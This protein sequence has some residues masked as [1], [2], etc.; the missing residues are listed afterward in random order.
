MFQTARNTIRVLVVGSLVLLVS[1]MVAPDAQGSLSW[2]SVYRKNRGNIVFQSRPFRTFSSNKGFAKIVRRA[3]RNRVLRRN[4][5]GT[6]SFYFVAFMKKPPKSHQVNLVWYRLGRKK[7]KEQVDYTRISVPPREVN[8]QAM[9]TL[10]S[11]V[12]KRR[13]RLEARITR[14][15]GGREVVYASCR[16]KLM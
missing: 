5:Y 1:I 6:W 14:I 9:V 7:K 2:D 16:V 10:D 12:F 3:K 13:D 11:E 15:V 8:L 4:R